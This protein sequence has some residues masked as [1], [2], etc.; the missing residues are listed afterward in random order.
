[1]TYK[2][3]DYDATAIAIASLFLTV[4]GDLSFSSLLPPQFA[5]VTLASCSMK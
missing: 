5:T 2:S 1:L 3:D 4:I